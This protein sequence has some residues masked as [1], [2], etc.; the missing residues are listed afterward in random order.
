MRSEAAE[1]L[2]QFTRPR[3]ARRIAVGR[4]LT[5]GVSIHAPARGATA[6]QRERRAG[7]RVSIHAPARGA[8]WRARCRRVANT[9]F[10]SRAREGRDRPRLYTIRGTSFQFTRPRG[11]RP[12]Q[13]EHPWSSWWFQFTRPRGARRRAPPG[14]ARGRVSIHAPARGATS[15]GPGEQVA[16]VFQFTRPRGARRIS[17]SR[18]TRD[19]KFQFTRPR[20]ARLRWSFGMTN[21]PPVSIH[22]PARGATVGYRMAMQRRSFN[23][24]AREGRDEMHLSAL[25]LMPV[26]I[27]APARGATGSFYVQ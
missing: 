8:T 16:G 26:S 25:R 2:F 21:T 3:G 27:H 15:P 14:A 4:Y 19:F 22:A 17:T 12:S 6:C 18:T 11:A 13:R 23:S 9:R 1:N 20:G 7:D 10:N 5:C 24:R